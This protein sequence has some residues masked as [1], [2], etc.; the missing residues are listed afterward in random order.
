VLAA[1]AALA[2]RR[3]L[4]PP[5]RGPAPSRLR[6]AFVLAAGC[7]AALLATRSTVPL[8]FLRLADGDV[9][10]SLLFLAG[11]TAAALA[12]LLCREHLPTPSQVARGLPVALL[13][14][15]LL[16]LAAA[17]LASRALYHLSLDG[18]PGRVAAGVLLAAA[19]FPL[20]AL[21]EGVLDAIRRAHGNGAGAHLRALAVAVPCWTAVAWSLAVAAPGLGRLAA[22]LAVAAALLAAL[23]GIVGA[24]AANFAAGAAF[25]AIATGWLVAVGFVRF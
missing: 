21:A 5:P 6:P 11:A 3:L 1:L 23:G 9:L 24:A 10:G 18:A 13:A 19:T 20:F 12:S 25:S 7:A 22:P 15:A 16:Y 17:L 2:S 8:R 14:G 4:A